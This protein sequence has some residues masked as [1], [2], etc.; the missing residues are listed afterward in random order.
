MGRPR[1]AFEFGGQRAR[2]HGGAQAV[3][4][5]RR[6]GRCEDDLDAFVPQQRHVVVEGPGVGVQIFAGTE[7][8]AG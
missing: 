4:I 5:H 7:L 3:R 2:P 6:G 8:Q 1:G